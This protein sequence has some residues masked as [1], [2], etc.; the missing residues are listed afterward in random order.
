[1]FFGVIFSSCIIHGFSSSG[2]S[3]VC[4]QPCQTHRASLPGPS[5][6]ISHNEDTLV[7]FLWKR[8]VRK[9]TLIF[10]EG[11]SEKIKTVEL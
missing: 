11:G 3:A 9:M 7:S 4:N 1:M 2:V 6:N 10:A 8:A 5:R